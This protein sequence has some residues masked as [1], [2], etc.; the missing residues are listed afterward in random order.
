MTRK[1]K[2]LTILAILA[3]ITLSTIPIQAQPPECEPPIDRAIYRDYFGG[4]YFDDEG[5]QVTL[6]VESSIE[7]AIAH[8]V[9]DRIAVRR[10]RYR[11]VEFSYAELRGLQQEV[12]DALS[13]GLVLDIQCVYVV[14]IARLGIDVVENR[15]IITLEDDSDEMIAGLL[16]LYIED[17][18]MIVFEQG[19]RLPCISGGRRR[20]VL[21]II[22]LVGTIILAV[23]IA[24]IAILHRKRRRRFHSVQSFSKPL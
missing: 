18:P 4:I 24:V 14:N 22:R 12:L 13:A 6:I 5:R 16:R 21:P 1:N 10:G 20:N 8:G 17:S 3:A 7:S 15:F 2:L 11:L 19:F 9:F 23:P